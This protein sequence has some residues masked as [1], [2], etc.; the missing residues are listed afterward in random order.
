MNNES[1]Y[2]IISKRLVYQGKRQLKTDVKEIGYEYDK[3]GYNENRGKNQAHVS[4]HI[5]LSHRKI[6]KNGLAFVNTLFV[7]IRKDGQTDIIITFDIGRFGT[8]LRFKI[9]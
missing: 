1:V 9:K 2:S 4:S 7:I 3:G 8:S 5:I 6:R